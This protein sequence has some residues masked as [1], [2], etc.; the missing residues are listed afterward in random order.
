MAAQG[1]SMNGRRQ[2]K[3]KTTCEVYAESTHVEDSLQVAAEHAAAEIERLRFAP[4]A[5]D[6]EAFGE[7]FGENALVHPEL[8]QHEFELVRIAVVADLLGLRN[9]L[10]SCGRIMLD[11]RGRVR[12]PPMAIRD[13]VRKDPSVAHQ[14]LV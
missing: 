10:E 8:G 3:R 7:Y 14:F 13:D 6:D 12:V 9:G 4:A 2:P 5:V 11:I 1:L